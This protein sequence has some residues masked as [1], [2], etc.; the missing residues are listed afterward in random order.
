MECCLGFILGH[1]GVDNM[2]VDIGIEAGHAL[3]QSEYL[4]PEL[5]VILARIRMGLIFS[6]IQVPRG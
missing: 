6:V 2:L 3:Q 1:Q 5:M 4:P